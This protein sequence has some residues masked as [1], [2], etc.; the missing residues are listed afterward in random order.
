MLPAARAKADVA[1]QRVA[2]ATERSEPGWCETACERLREFARAQ[3]GVFTVELARMAFAKD[4]PAP[5]D[6]R[7]WGQVTRMATSRGYID[8][9]HGE[10]F[11]AASSNGSPKPVYRRGPNAGVKLQ[12]ESPHC[13]GVAFSLNDPRAKKGAA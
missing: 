6:L 11:S 9:V 2:D 12:V 5:G 4:L 1:I 3:S 10:F 8:R 13:V 7:A